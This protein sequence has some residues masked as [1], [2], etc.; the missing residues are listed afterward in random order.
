MERGAAPC[1]FLPSTIIRD[2]DV[3]FCRRDVAR[4]LSPVAKLSPNGTAVQASLSTLMA[5]TLAPSR[6]L[7]STTYKTSS[8]VTDLQRYVGFAPTTS[9]P[10]NGLLRKVAAPNVPVLVNRK[11]YSPFPLPSTKPRFRRIGAHY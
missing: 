5:L 11:A 10:S 4:R 6:L 9:F 3:G 2:V 7:S 8:C 1:T